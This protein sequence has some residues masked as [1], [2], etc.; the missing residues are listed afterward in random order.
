MENK[1]LKK[2]LVLKKNILK[3]LTKSLLAIII[4]LVG[5]ILAKKSP[6]IKNTIIENVYEKN[7]NFTKAKELY[8][9]YFGSLLPWEKVVQQEKPV[10]NEK[11]TYSAQNT[12][13]DGVALT[14][15]ENYLVPA[16]ESGI[17]IFIGEK[18][19]YG[20]TIIIE[21]TNGIDV[22]YSNITFVDLKLYDYIE[23]GKLLGEAKDNKIYLVFSKEGKYLDYKNY[24]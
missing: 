10:F 24:I 8:K 14:V 7:L 20:N 12:Y 4:T 15:E 2:K 22:F 16:L 19:D 17:V 5:L 23:K 13:K 11:L 1:V 21:Q 3:I 9:K 18:S 6:T